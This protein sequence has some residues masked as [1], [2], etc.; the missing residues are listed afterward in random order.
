[1]RLHA[2][3]APGAGIVVA[4]GALA[5]LIGCSARA[6]SRGPG[7]PGPTVAPA[8]ASPS[9]TT[10]AATDVTLDGA[11]LP[12][13]LPDAISQRVPTRVVVRELG[14]DLPVVRPPPDPNHYPY[15]NAAEFLPTLSVPG[16]PGPTFLYAHARA[17][18]FLPIL[19]ASRIADGRA[20]IGDRVE[21]YTSDDRVFEYT[22]TTVQRHVTSL[23]AAYRDIAEQ[24]ILQ[25]SEGPHGTIPKTMVIAAPNGDEPAD[26]ADAHPRTHVVRCDP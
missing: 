10:A 11:G 2:S 26:H 6:V 5:V 15:C 1:M 23:D 22:V 14:I 9:R 12:T 17:G 19:E 7:E 21:V 13:L 18:M 25:T 3:R 20:M 4:C 16:R 24:L 8:S